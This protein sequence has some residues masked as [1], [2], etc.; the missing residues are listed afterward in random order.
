[1]KII[2]PHLHLFNRVEGQYHWLNPDNPP[3]WNDKAK[4]NRDFGLSDVALEQP[5]ELCG[6][7]HIEAG[8][9]N[10]HPWRE[11][12]W[13][14][15][16][17]SQIIRT[18]ACV[19]LT[20][21]CQKFTDLLDKLSSY[22]TLCGVRHILDEDAQRLLSSQQ[23][24]AN[25]AL[26]AQRGLI[27][28]CQLAGCDN[29]AINQ[30]THILTQQVDLKLVINHAGFPSLDQSTSSPWFSNMHRLAK[31]KTVTIKASG[32][33]MQNRAYSTDTIQT[34]VEQLIGLFGIDRVML[35]SNF[36]L[37]LFSH[38]YQAL[39]QCYSQLA[40]SDAQ[41]NAL[42]YKNALRCYHFS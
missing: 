25:L 42:L 23:V 22:K 21:S 8:Y 30:L 37:C 1:M 2:D 19:D 15:S 34:V 13:L 33:E 9:N 32:W 20:L 29:L 40:F 4:I 38:S 24:Q 36:P 27:F 5:F 10:S 41:L 12:Q 6:L 31:F 7:V 26:I 18:V 17:S 28:E 14:E 39:W 11:V 3:F 16:L 35:A